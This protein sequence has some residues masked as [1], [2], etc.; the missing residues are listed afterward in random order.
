M[1][2]MKEFAMKI[3]F[4]VDKKL[5]IRIFFLNIYYII[6][7]FLGYRIEKTKQYY[8]IVLDHPILIN[9]M[10]EKNIKLL[11]LNEKLIAKFGIKLK[12]SS[13]N[14]LMVTNVPRCFLRRKS[15][16]SEFKLFCSVKNL[17]TDI[18]ESL[19]TTN[20]ISIL[21]KSI[22]NSVASEACRGK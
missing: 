16:Y 20:G 10:E 21:P 9:D 12:F 18:V 5:S 2:L 13:N 1:R 4:K 15:E 11:F 3:F 14:S 22:H 6:F 7:Y 17:L 8:S 19:E